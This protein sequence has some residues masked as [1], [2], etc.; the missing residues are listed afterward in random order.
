[1]TTQSVSSSAATLAPVAPPPV[2]VMASSTAASNN[3]WGLTPIS[4]L[5]RTMEY[6]DNDTLMI[7]CLVC[8]QIRDLFWTGQEMEKKLVRIFELS[9]LK[10]NNDQHFNCSDIGQSRVRRFVS[11]MNQYFQ[12][13]TK[14][15]SYKD[16]NT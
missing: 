1:M 2:V 3:T 15:E 6:M 9:A 16:S 11:N 10:E 5:L 8:K 4:L 12:N 13:V 7:M 14:L